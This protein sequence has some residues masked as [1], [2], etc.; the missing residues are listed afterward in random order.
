MR[1]SGD[2]ASLAQGPA[3]ARAWCHGGMDSVTDVLGEWTAR[4]WSGWMISS[5]PSLAGRG[6]PWLLTPNRQYLFML[7]TLKEKSKPSSGCHLPL[8]LGLGFDAAWQV[9][10]W[11]GAPF[12][13]KQKQLKVIPT[14]LLSMW[15]P[16]PVFK[17]D[18]TWGLTNQLWKALRST[19]QC[20]PANQCHCRVRVCVYVLS[21][22]S[23][24]LSICLAYLRVHSAPETCWNPS[25]IKVLLL[26]GLQL[27]STVGRIG[28]FAVGRIWQNH[29]SSVNSRGRDQGR[30]LITTAIL[31]KHALETL[32][33]V[34]E[35]FWDL[36]KGL[37]GAQATWDPHW[38]RFNA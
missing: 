1:L 25:V 12:R 37:W 21:S 5:G 24:W 28:E 8:D 2:K 20:S 30:L 38:T 6:Q 17:D 4:F 7:E 31:W 10:L 27:Y 18:G 22:V 9:L 15:T 36:H 13:S 11:T 35:V 14:D 33:F 34:L 29:K 19:L 26:L 32:I 3:L 16:C 23:P